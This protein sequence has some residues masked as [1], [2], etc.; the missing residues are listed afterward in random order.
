LRHIS[1]QVID[2][3]N[4]KT[5]CSISTTSKEVSSSLSNGN[6]VQAAESLG[7]LFGKQIKEAGID[8]VVFDRGGYLYHGR[9]KAFADGARE[10]GVQI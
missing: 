1:A 8:S 4:G 5:L 6:K 7:K 2:D 3:V 9:I 10:A